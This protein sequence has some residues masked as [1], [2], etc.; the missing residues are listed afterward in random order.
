MG[1]ER[2]LV[3]GATGFVGQ[4]LCSTLAGSYVVRG[5]KRKSSLARCPSEV[6]SVIGELAA[7]SEWF[8]ALDGIKVVVHCA[9]RVHVTDGY[10]AD[11]LTAFRRINVDGTLNLARQA[12]V[13]GVRRFIFLSSV[14]VNGKQSMA[15]NPFA[16]D[17]QPNPCDPYGV[18]KKEAEDGLRALAVETGMDVVIIRPP[19]V[20]GPAVKA[21]FLAMMRWLLCGLPLPFGS[22][23]ENRRSLVATDNLVDL[24]ATCI[25]HPA[26]ANQTFLVSDGEDLSTADLLRRTGRALGTPVRLIPIPLGLLQSAATVLGRRDVAQRLCG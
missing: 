12:A 25:N 4:A 16:A 15:G 18:S 13:A 7:D 3:T 6:Q 22:A 20:Y 19:L 23:T 21:N 14:K 9:A 26:A 10:S 1:K 5:V 2:V 17:Q 11:S 24:I 8:A